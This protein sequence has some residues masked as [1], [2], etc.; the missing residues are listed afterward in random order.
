[1]AEVKGAT[2]ETRRVVD[3]VLT[4]AEDLSSQSESLSSSV[5]AF[6]ENVKAA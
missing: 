2:D 3:K 4:A 1:M 6:L 5:N